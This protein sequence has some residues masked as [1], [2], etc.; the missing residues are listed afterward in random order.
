M[1]RMFATAAAVMICLGLALQAHAMMA[2]PS[3]IGDRVALAQ[4]IVVGKVTAIEDKTVNAMRFPGDKDKAQYGVA[5]I[6]VE[7]GILGAKAKSKVRLGFIPPPAP[8]PGKPILLKGRGMPAPVVGQEACWILTKNID[9]D[10]YVTGAY[11][12]VIDKKNANFEK[13]VTQLKRCA[14]QA[15]PG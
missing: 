3:P 1:R 7:D 8:N 2:A 15:Q 10:F 6:E 13:D 11:F 4:V 12:T 9:G 5:V 14:R